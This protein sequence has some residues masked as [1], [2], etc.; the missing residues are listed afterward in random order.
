MSYGIETGPRESRNPEVDATTTPSMA[1]NTCLFTKAV[2]K[3]EI[4]PNNNM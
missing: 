1:L 2:I 4:G 3:L